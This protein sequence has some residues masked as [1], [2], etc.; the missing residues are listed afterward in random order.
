MERSSRM[1]QAIIVLFI[2]SSLFAYALYPYINAFLTA[3]ILYVILKPL[4]RFLTIDHKIRSD[5][6][7]IFVLIVSVIII[8]VPVYI[9]L[10][11][12]YLEIQSLFSDTTWVFSYIELATRYIHIIESIVLPV[13]IDL[14]LE[15]RLMEFLSTLANLIS[16][17]A[18]DTLSVIGQKLIELVIMYFL[19]FYL[20]VGDNSKFAQ[21]LRNAVPFNEDNTKKLLNK[22]SSLV[23][24]ILFSSGIIAVIQGTILTITFLLLGIEGAFFW[25]FVTL[26]LSFL[27]MVGP[28]VI[29]LPSLALQLIQGDYF[30][31]MGVL[32]GG[33][34]HTLVDEVLRPVVQK[35][36]GQIHP[37]V[38]IVGVLTGLKLFGLLG[39]ILGPLLIS[40][41]LL[42]ALMIHDEY[43]SDPDSRKYEQL[44]SEIVKQE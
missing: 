15:R 17:A 41:V 33:I 31:A 3:F 4:H 24:T 7:A 38:T 40:Y 22:F 32:I 27:P 28:P 16:G 34:I 1:W 13:E 43:L 14:E 6:S 39:I 19:L 5:I 37:L 42:V 36:V 9:L 20:L 18:V 35:R 30:I 26:I 12:V 2:L 23:K 21:S 8:L 44:I 11:L 25:G 29:W 10:A